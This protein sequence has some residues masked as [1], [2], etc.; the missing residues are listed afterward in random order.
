MVFDGVINTNGGGFSSVRRD[1]TPGLLREATG[2][3]LNVRS[4]GREYKVTMKT[5]ARLRGRYI[6][7]QGVIPPSAPGEWA[8]VTVNFDDLKASIFGRP[9]R[10][11]S[12]APAEVSEIGIII[13]DGQDGPFE[14]HVKDIA[15][16][17]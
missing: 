13:A 15:S 14:L 10:G 16:C 17:G 1:V 7:F 3:T 12:F 4:D 11:A 8:V 9:V 5:Q 6:S 2:L